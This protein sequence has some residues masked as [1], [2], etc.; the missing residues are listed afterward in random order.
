MKKNNVSI[1][2][3]DELDKHLQHTSPLTWISLGLVTVILIGFFAWSAIFKMHIPFTGEAV[4]T[5][6]QAVLNIEKGD[7]NKFTIDQ[8]VIISDIEGKVESFNSEGKPVASYFDLAD[9]EYT[10]KIVYEKRPIDFLIGK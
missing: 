3:P 10:F 6:G 8:T 2:N 5:S 9:G 1:S 4:I 7:I